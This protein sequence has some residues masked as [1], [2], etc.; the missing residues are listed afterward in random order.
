[1]WRASAVISMLSR[2]SAV[3][4]VLAAC[5]TAASA[6][7]AGQSRCRPPGAHTLA[8]DRTA[9]VFS[10][11][12]TVYGCIKATGKRR[13]LGGAG[14]CNL[15]AGRVAPVRLAGDLVAYGVETCGVDTGSST[16]VV[17][18]LA[19]GRRL[20]DLPAFM[21]SL[22]A[23]SFVSVQALVLRHD[24]AVG[25]IAGG[26]SIVS[27]GPP[28]Y[29]VHRFEGGTSSLLESGTAISPSSLRLAGSRMTW[30]DGGVTHSATLG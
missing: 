30:R 5:A 8:A 11:H 2:T 21:L 25:W 10:W 23:E 14:F 22:G 12:R 18:N 26:Q 19:T 17:R 24:G 3:M 6:S 1:M 4:L 16:V 27:H 15:P 20:A 29:E 9:R 7:A 13:N 28:S